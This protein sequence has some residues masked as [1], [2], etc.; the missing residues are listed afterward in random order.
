[1]NRELKRRTD[2]FQ[3]FPNPESVIRLVGALLV[4]VSDEMISAD[5]L[6][7]A[8]PASNPSPQTA[9][10]GLWLDQ[11]GV[12]WCRQVRVVATDLVDSYR[13]GMAGRLDHAIKVADRFHVFRVAQRCLTRVRTR[14]QREQTGHRGRK[15]DPLYRQ[16]RIFDTGAERLNQRGVERLL[17]GFRLGD[18]HDEVL[19]AWVEKETVRDVYLT[20][21]I[22]LATVPLARATTACQ[23]DEVPEI[24]ALGRTLSRWRP[25]ILNHHRTGASNGP[26]EDMNLCI[27][28]VKRAG[29]G[30]HRFDHYRL[31][32]LLHTG[33]CDWNQL[34]SRPRPIRTRCSPL[35]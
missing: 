24:C 12:E 33:G 14:V 22:N 7:I 34:T 21:N 6:Y 5:R 27:K 10:L 19:G 29:H 18:P 26:T 13:K 35:K 32:V 28:K 17:E 9:D 16:R 1:L 15:D 23:A 30:F 31:C 11:Q 20:D 25:E 2:V 4:E 8:A 3:I